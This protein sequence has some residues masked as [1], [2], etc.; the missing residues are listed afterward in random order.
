VLEKALNKLALI[1][2]ESSDWRVISYEGGKYGVH[3]GLL[4]ER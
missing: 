2:H 4:E 1:T 3:K